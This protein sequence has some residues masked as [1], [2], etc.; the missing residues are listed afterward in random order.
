[1]TLKET[2]KATQC[3][4]GLLGTS[5]ETMPMEME[6]NWQQLEQGRSQFL[7]NLLSDGGE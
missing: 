3:F 2:L 1:M 7:Q 5:T 6:R 4:G